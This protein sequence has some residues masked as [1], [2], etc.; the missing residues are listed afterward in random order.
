MISLDQ[1]KMMRYVFFRHRLSLVET[2]RIVNL[3]LNLWIWNLNLHWIPPCHPSKFLRKHKRLFH[4]LQPLPPIMRL[5]IERQIYIDH[6]LQL[7]LQQYDRVPWH[8]L[9]PLNNL[10][11]LP[12]LYNSY[13]MCQEQQ[14]LRTRQCERLD[15]D[16]IAQ[17]EQELGLHLVYDDL[18]H[19]WKRKLNGLFPC[20]NLVLG[21]HGWHILKLLPYLVVLVKDVQ[22]VNRI[23]VWIIQTLS[24]CLERCDLL[25]LHDQLPQIRGQKRR[26]V[27]QVEHAK[28]EENELD[29]AFLGEILVN[30]LL[31]HESVERLDEL[32]VLVELVNKVCRFGDFAK[33]LG[34][35]FGVFEE[36]NAEVVPGE[37]G[38]ILN[39]VL[40]EKFGYFWKHRH[41]SKE[42]LNTHSLLIIL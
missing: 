24:I 15:L 1:L 31:E 18:A 37:M 30:F 5:R 26:L 36:G 34:R 16:Q 41:V 35:N 6:R 29:T 3:C 14:L 8:G 32:E 21:L 25:L 9:L 40:G 20:Y 12:H 19:S 17:V 27:P 2:V 38:G 11:M 23:V 7:P 39:R 4:L 28:Q 33:L 22:I 42:L 10:P 13:S